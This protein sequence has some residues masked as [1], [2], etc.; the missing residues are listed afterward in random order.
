MA[1]SRMSSRPRV[2]KPTSW[3][4]FIAHASPDK[5]AAESL[6]RSL[7]T[8][9]N[10][11][12]YIDSAGLL[13]G[14]PWQ[15][16][17]KEALAASRVSVVLIS[18]HTPKAWYQQE[19][20][21]LAIELAREEYV[22]HRIVPVY[23]KGARARDTPYGLRRLNSLQEG[24]KGMRAIAN[25]LARTLRQGRRGGIEALAGSVR[26]TDELWSKA[27]PAYG[28]DTGVPK[29]FRRTF[30]LDN[31]DLVSRDQGRELK[32]VTH[33]QLRRKLGAGAM[34]YVEVLERSMEVN[35]AIWTTSYPRRSVSSRDRKRTKEAVVAMSADLR[36]VLDTIKRAGFSLDDHYETIRNIVSRPPS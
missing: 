24:P 20:V 18:T 7:E 5:K 26:V 12:V 35:K 3:D 33:K 32:R 14:D 15:S 8:T 19:E 11:R 6:K 4:F 28:G 23:L 10:A 31:G 34:E 13:G 22:A 29:R 25:E 17:L 21:V 27:A 30:T 1:S 36:A 2:R 16:G 9:A